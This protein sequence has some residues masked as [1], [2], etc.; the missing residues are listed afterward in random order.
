MIGRGVF[1]GV[2][3]PQE[4]N[5]HFNPSHYD[6][7]LHRCLV[8]AAVDCWKSH[9]GSPLIFFGESEAEGAPVKVILIKDV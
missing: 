9:C 2:W 6:R 8:K 1:W 4:N 5:S 7:V 3:V